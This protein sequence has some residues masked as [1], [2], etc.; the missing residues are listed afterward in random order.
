MKLKKPKFW[1]YNKPNFISHL[2]NP[3]AKIF[4][5][6]L[7]FSKKSKNKISGIKSICVGNIYVGGTGKTSIAIELKKILDKEKIKTCFIKKEYKDQI[8]EQ[9]LLE[10][11]G[12]TFINKSRLKALKNAIKENYDL[13]IFDDGLQD[14][15]ISYDLSF[16]CFNKKNLIG[17]GRLIP[18]GPLREN[19]KNI[20]NYDDIFLNG[21]DENVDSFVNIL[22]N[23]NMNLNIYESKYEIQNFDQINKE[24]DYIVFSGIGNHSTFIDTLKKNKIKIIKDIEYPDHYEYSQEDLN[25]IFEIAK[26]N[27][28]K[29]LTT[30][31]DYLRLNQKNQD[32][33]NFIKIFLK[34]DKI[35]RLRERLKILYENN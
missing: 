25:K 13:A 11:F 17:N 10:K 18:A 22:R 20:K 4:E 24:K 15:S 23:E 2:L 6:K 5:F 16:V 26:N 1:D 3:L 8:D 33:I 7:K 35:D 29:I 9:K 30:E 34:I 21:N 19:I 31:K 12:K 14:T 28:A 27:N 32:N